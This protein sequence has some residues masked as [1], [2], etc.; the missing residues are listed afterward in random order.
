MNVLTALAIGS[1]A[2]V[3]LLAPLLIRRVLRRY[4]VVDEP[5]ER[6]SHA[7]PTLRG[8]GAAPLIGVGTAAAL[9]PLGIAGDQLYLLLISLVP[10]AAVGVVGLVEDVRGLPILTRLGLQVLAGTG[11]SLALTGLLDVPMWLTLATPL[12]FAAYVNFANFM[13]GVNA[14]SSLHGLV[15]GLSFAAMGL[16]TSA[17]W[18]ATAGAL[19]AAVFLAFLP[20]NL[21]PPGMFLG[22]VGSYLLGGLLASAAIIAVGSGLGVAAAIA[23]LSI[24]LADTLATLLTRAFKGESLHRP[25]RSHVYQRLLAFGL[26]HVQSAVVAAGFTAAAVIAA[27]SAEALGM[28]MWAWLALAIIAAAYLSLPAIITSGRKEGVHS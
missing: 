17:A 11:L 4:G 8:G 16:T 5:N 14:I 3:A 27:L 20:W 25:H 26:S 12:F 24:Y 19:T 1:G 18:L 6:S 15:A 21:T 22:D 10:S 23:P 9:A 7:A 13:D 28:E 2:L